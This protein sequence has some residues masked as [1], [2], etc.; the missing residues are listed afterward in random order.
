LSASDISVE[1]VLDNILSDNTIGYRIIG[2]KSFVFFPKQAIVEITGKINGS[3]GNAAASGAYIM[4]GNP[5]EAGKY[6]RVEGTGLIT[7]GKSGEPIIGVTVQI[8]NTLTGAVSNS[9]GIY[10]LSLE[11]GLY[12]VLIS[13]VGYEI[14]KRDLRV[15][16]N[17]N[18][19]IELFDKAIQ[20][21]DIVVY[22]ER[23]DR[24]V[25][26]QQMSLLELDTR[27]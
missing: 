8:E 14:A 15:L 26:S 27:S 25:T 6:R 7:D 12:T 5:D 9:E 10:R 22:G 11:P 13:S 2:D 18:L 19:D 3:S 1:S 16:S 4:I 23:V 17:G 24:N 20:I 21:E